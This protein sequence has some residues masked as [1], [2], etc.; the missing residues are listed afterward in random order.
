MDKH[1]KKISSVYVEKSFIYENV[2][3]PL[4]FFKHNIFQKDLYKTLLVNNHLNKIQ[5]GRMLDVGCGK[6]LKSRIFFD[7]GLSPNNYYGIDLSKSRLSIAKSIIK[8]AD[9]LLSSADSLPY[10]DDYFLCQCVFIYT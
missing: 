10:D 5:E 3:K 4:Q 7:L 8:D 9:Y 6:G 1:F 2:R